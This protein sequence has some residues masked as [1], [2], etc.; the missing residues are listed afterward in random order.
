MSYHPAGW[1][2]RGGAD[3][4]LATAT[5]AA[6]AGRQHIVYGV[7]ASFSAAAAGKL[8]TIKDGTTIVFQAYVTNQLSVHFPHGIAITPGAAC[9]AE[10]AASGT[11]A[12]L[13]DVDLH[14]ITVG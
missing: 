9:A 10:L 7:T 5:K 4:A 6:E 13:G 11:G 14:G 1:V 2:A 8:L 3:N 12:V